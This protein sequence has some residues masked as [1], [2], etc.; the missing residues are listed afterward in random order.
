LF[1]HGFR[2]SDKRQIAF[3]QVIEIGRVLGDFRSARI[4]PLDKV[5]R[6]TLVTD[7]AVGPRKPSSFLPYMSR[8]I[9]SRSATLPGG[10]CGV[11]RIRSPGSRA[12]MSVDVDHTLVL[13][14]LAGQHH[15]FF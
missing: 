1:R 6:E 7:A 15:F 10:I 9:R 8:T 2:R 4:V 14:H 13:Q 5:F 12:E 11:L 3:E